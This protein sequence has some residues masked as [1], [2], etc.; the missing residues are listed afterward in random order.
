MRGVAVLMVL[1]VHSTELSDI[2]QLKP[3]ISNFI[4][5]GVF[6]VQFFFV[7]SSYTLFYTLYHH[8]KSS[9]NFY[10][11]RLFRIAPAYY[12]AI[13]FYSFHNQ[14]FGVGELLNFTFTHSFSPQ[15]INSIVPGGWSIGIEMF[16]YL[17]VPFLFLYI[18]NLNKAIYF[19]SIT[20]IVKLLCY[21]LIKLPIFLVAANDGS[22]M[23]FWFPNQL[24]VFAIGF[25]LFFCI[26]KPE[27]IS[28]QLNLALLGVAGLVIFSL[29]T[30]LQIFSNHIVI[31]VAFAVVLAFS[32]N[33]RS[34]SL[35]ENKILLFIGKI[36]YSAYL[37]QYATI[38]LL[39]EIGFYNFISKDISASSYINFALNF[40][41][42]FMFT[43]FTAYISFVT[44]EKPG[45]KLGLKIV[46]RYF[47][48][49]ER[50]VNS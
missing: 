33:V 6:G 8:K 3:M 29:M 45:Q 19:F 26:Q 4:E 40:F 13:L 36:S 2:T 37:W 48:Q 12:V 38:F 24:P 17:I 39:K 25:I 22:F 23:Y 50:V 21:Y 42:L 28:K 30:S 34:Y 35:L 18:T 20:L 46:N 47:S 14:T 32:A 5:S 7:I 31:S 44:I 49:H 16:F 11:R 43:S 27:M 15:Y 41:I 10:L 9:V 1:M